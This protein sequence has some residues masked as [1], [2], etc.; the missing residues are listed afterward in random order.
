MNGISHRF[1]VLS[2]I[3]ELLS[4]RKIQEVKNIYRFGDLLFYDFFPYDHC[5]AVYTKS[6][7]CVCFF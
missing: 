6:F 3:V 5:S 7:L 1:I 2:K 4:L